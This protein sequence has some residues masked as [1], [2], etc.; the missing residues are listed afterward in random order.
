[1]DPSSLKKIDLQLLEHLEALISERHVTRAAERMGLGQ[2]AM[3]GILSKLRDIVGDPLLVR[4]SQ[5]MVPTE[6]ALEVATQVREGLNLIRNALAA[7]ARFD[8]A[9]SAKQFRVIAPD[10]LAFTMLPQLLAHLEAAAPQ[11][12]VVF[13]PADVRL[14]RELLETDECDLVISYLPAPP[15]GLH[16]SVVLHQKLCSIARVG[17]PDIDGTLSIDQFLAWPHLVFGAGPMPFSTIENEVDRALRARKLT[18]RIGARVSNILLMPRVIAATHMIATVSERTARHFAPIAPVQVLAPP[19][20]L[21]EPA[22]VMVWHG[23][24][25]HDA[26]HQWLR[27]VIR[28]IAAGL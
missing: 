9:V 4:T 15:E 20:D 19:I 8:P 26:P 25:Q 10:S 28:R 11:I 1:M 12:S 6:R 5:G 24:T 23:R 14:S 3:S 21:P 16:A 7:P 2:P 22:V 27:G 13:A 17:H 18:R